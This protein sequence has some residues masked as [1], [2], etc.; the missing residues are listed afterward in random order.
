MILFLLQLR[1]VQAYR[2][3]LR[4]R[5]KPETGKKSKMVASKS[6]PAL[7]SRSESKELAQLFEQ[8]HRNEVLKPE[9]QTKA[10]FNMIS[11]LLQIL[12]VQACRLRLPLEKKNI[13]LILHSLKEKRMHAEYQ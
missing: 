13:R 2:L 1:Q 3:R 12:H 10:N 11:F 4:P 9:T 7:Q 8:E 6:S 5:Y